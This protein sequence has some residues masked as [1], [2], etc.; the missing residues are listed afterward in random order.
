M[1]YIKD[2][3]HFYLIAAKVSFELSE[4]ER[5]MRGK[6]QYLLGLREKAL[7]FKNFP[8]GFADKRYLKIYHTGFK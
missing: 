1:Q 8:I 2:I 4:K 7:K 5:T 3:I 6:A